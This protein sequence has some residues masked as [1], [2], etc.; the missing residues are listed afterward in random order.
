MDNDPET[1]EPTELDYSS[2][3]A[4]LESILNAL[5]GDTLDV[6]G[7]AK[8]VARAARLIDHCRTRIENA[9]TEVERVV[10]ELDNK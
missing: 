5:E 9:R 1:T 8:K 10:V 6:D 7:L 2:A 3:M 4:E